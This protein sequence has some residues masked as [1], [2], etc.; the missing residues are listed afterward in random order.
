MAGFLPD[1]INN[2]VSGFENEG[3]AALWRSVTQK[4]K[5]SNE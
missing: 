2:V 1:V 3:F 5:D 4:E